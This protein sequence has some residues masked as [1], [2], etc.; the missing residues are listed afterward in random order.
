MAGGN[1]TESGLAKLCEALKTENCKEEKPKKKRR[2]HRRKQPKAKESE[3]GENKT[4][5]VKAKES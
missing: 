5:M 2:S 4:I 3:N 1:M